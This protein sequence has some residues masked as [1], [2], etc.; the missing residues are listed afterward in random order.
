MMQ[1]PENDWNPGM[2]YSSES[3]HQELSNENQQ[4]RV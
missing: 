3:T 2:R 1:N 4:D